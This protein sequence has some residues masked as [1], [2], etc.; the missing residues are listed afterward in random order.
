[1]SSS[2][3]KSNI[4]NI[5]QVS[6]LT[7]LQEK[8]CNAQNLIVRGRGRSYTD[9]AL[10]RTLILEFEQINGFVSLNGNT[11][12]LIV[13]S[14]ATFHKI[15]N[16]IAGYNWFFPVVPESKFISVGAA[17]AGNVIGMNQHLR[18]SFLKHV[19]WLEVVLA[20]GEVVKCSKTEKPDLF[21][22]TCG[23]QGLTGAI[24][25]VG[26]QLIRLK[27]TVIKKNIIPV[28]SF[29]EMME[30]LELNR[31]HEYVSAWVD[32]YSGNNLKGIVY[33]GDFLEQKYE[34]GSYDFEYESYSPSH[35]EMPFKSPFN[36][37]N[38]KTSFL[39]NKMYFFY[40]KA[41]KNGVFTNIDNFFFPAD[42]IH[43]WDMFYGGDGYVQY[44]FVIPKE[45][46]N[47]LKQIVEY[48][49]SLKILKT[50]G[51][52]RL[53]SKGEMGPGHLC[54]EKDGY[55][56]LVEFKRDDTLSP[57]YERLNDMV[58]SCGGCVYLPSEEALDGEFFRK[59][60]P[61]QV[62]DFMNV[63]AKYD[64][65]NKFRSLQSERLNIMY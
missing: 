30:T 14:A 55:S 11:G 61:N 33:S 21:Y 22:A 38:R 54:F 20:S 59:F 10:N 63:K 16:L 26:L 25:R 3:E 48:L 53:C 12:E 15:I 34:N 1:M 51:S 44:M 64:S 28:Y 52:I 46:E 9:S 6:S 8:I 36:L 47:K 43:N 32:L 19:R 13:Y 35:F 58:N 65:G 27:S 4:Y 7:A 60:Y 39:F 31:P 18:K 57:I 2:E 62:D 40:N 42:Y 29:Y 41:H 37:L 5:E 45:E 50:L 23:G 49:I 24:Y 56:M 17:V